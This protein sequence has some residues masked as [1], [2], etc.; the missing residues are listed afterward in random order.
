MARIWHRPG[1]LMI[2][3]AVLCAISQ[4]ARGPKGWTASEV[5][6][7]AAAVAVVA[8]LAWRVVRGGAISRGLLVVYTAGSVVAVVWGPDIKASGLVAIG[9]LASCL[10]QLALLVATP[11]YERTRKDGA[12]R[13][14]SGAPLWPTPPRWMAAAGLSA[15]LLITL[16]F[17][18]SM[19]WKSVPC[20]PTSSVRRTTCATLTEGFPVRFLSAMPA[21]PGAA[22]PAISK[23]AAAEDIT[24][25]V[26]LS[27]AACYLMW[28]PSRRPDA[29]LRRD[30]AAGNRLDAL[31]R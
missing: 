9:L 31:A 2:V 18:S 24:V 4:V 6:T 27:Y 12:G 28:L 13:P 7:D 1:V 29:Q 5:S 20:A 25:W 11:V 3:Y 15:G 14:P 17:L 30:S 19:S 21:A 16:L 10:G 22:Y 23:G 26:A 8:F